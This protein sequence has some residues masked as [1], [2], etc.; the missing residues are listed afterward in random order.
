[1]VVLHFAGFPAPVEEMAAAAGL[2]LSRVVED[3][4]HAL[5]TRVG[6]RWVGTLSAATSFSF[7]ATKNLPIG[8]GGMITTDDPDI[9][10]YARQVRIHGMTQ[11]AWKR[12]LPGSGWRYGVAVAGVK[13]N[14][15][16]VQAAIGRAQL[17]HFESWQ[18]RRE[19]LARDFDERLARIEGLSGPAW[20]A[21]GLHAWHLYVIQVQPEFGVSRD[22]LITR[23]SLRGVDCSVHFIPLHHQPYFQ[24]LLAAQGPQE[25]PVADEVFPRIVSLPFYPGLSEEMTDR[26]WSEIEAIGESDSEVSL[27]SVAAQ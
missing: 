11:D 16:D 10:A 24:E 25:F 7:Y 23:L 6:N 5:G 4:A 12:Y 14:M 26:L 2:P 27:Q 1:M 9:A 21:D 20:P 8:E 13:A 17:K 22:D 19:R 3:A 15:T 18:D